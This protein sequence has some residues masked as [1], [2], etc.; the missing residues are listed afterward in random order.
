MRFLH[1]KWASRKLMVTL[2]ALIAPLVL[3]AWRLVDFGPLLTP[4]LVAVA[5][6]YLVMQGY[7]DKNTP[8]Q[9]QLLRRGPSPGAEYLRGRQD[10]TKG[11]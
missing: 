7:V 5:V 8:E 3:E 4:A 1:S 9:V 10:A 6:V 11:E 2:A